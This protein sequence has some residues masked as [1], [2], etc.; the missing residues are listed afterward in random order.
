MYIMS[1]LTKFLS[2]LCFKGEL[3]GVEYL[4]NQTG[5]PAQDYNLAI[6]QSED[7]EITI[8]EDEEESELGD[9]LDLTVPT[10]DTQ[11]TPAAAAAAATSSQASAASVVPPSAGAHS[12][13]FS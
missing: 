2:M 3:I 4:Y 5:R 12:C 11:E 9:F 7:T 13:E 1:R 6:Q 10:L 8:E